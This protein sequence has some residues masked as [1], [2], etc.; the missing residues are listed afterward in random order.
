VVSPPAAG[1]ASTWSAMAAAPGRIFARIAQR[2]LPLAACI[3][4]N[5]R[6]DA[7]DRRSLVAY[8]H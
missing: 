2:L 5:W 6:T 3:W 7:D 1:Q 4:Q 8:D